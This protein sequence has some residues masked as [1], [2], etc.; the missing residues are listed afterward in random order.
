M[1]M[2][3]VLEDPDDDGS[4]ADQGT[5]SVF[6]NGKSVRGAVKGKGASDTGEHSLGG[7]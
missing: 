2:K 4:S 3:K 1:K 6:V 7:A 5:S